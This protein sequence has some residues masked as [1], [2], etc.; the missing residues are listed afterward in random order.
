MVNLSGVRA[1]DMSAAALALLTL[2]GIAQSVKGLDLRCAPGAAP[3]AVK[4]S[5]AI[6]VRRSGQPRPASACLGLSRRSLAQVGQVGPLYPPSGFEPG[7]P[8]SDGE[9]DAVTPWGRCTK[10]HGAPEDAFVVSPSEFDL[11][12]ATICSADRLLWMGVGFDDSMGGAAS[13]KQA[14]MCEKMASSSRDRNPRDRELPAG[15]N[16]AP[17]AHL[18]EESFSATAVHFNNNGSP[19]PD[20]TA[21][22]LC[23]GAKSA[24][25]LATP[26][27][28]TPDDAGH[29]FDGVRG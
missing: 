13:E 5:T 20:T 12:D 23:S 3:V 26:S 9:D 1:A 27:P 18:E 17:H 19:G 15:A 21:H 10:T 14:D 22:H 8:R 28:L 6:R 11:A 25:R 29:Q 2:S 7:S 4:R 24:G 16:P